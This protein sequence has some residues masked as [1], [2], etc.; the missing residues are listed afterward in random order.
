MHEQNNLY[1]NSKTNSPGKR[2]KE[3]VTIVQQA[4][5]KVKGFEKLYKELQRAI[6]VSGKSTTTLSNYSRQLAHLALYYQVLH[7]S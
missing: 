3:Y 7:R 5:K 1:A 2:A 6:N 4:I